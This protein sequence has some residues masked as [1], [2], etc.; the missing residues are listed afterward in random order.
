MKLMRNKYDKLIILVLSLSSIFIINHVNKW[1]EPFMYTMAVALTVYSYLIAIGI[2][3]SVT[4][5]SIWSIVH[6]I[7]VATKLRMENIEIMK[8]L[9]RTM[10]EISQGKPSN[11]IVVKY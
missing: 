8:S 5:Y 4:I 1:H 7:K 2:V 3:T 6:N 11:M 9:T 10:N